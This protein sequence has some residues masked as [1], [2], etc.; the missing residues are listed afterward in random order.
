MSDFQDDDIEVNGTNFS[1][2]LKKFEGWDS[3]TLAGEGYFLAITFDDIPE[4][5][6]AVKVGLVP[7]ASGMAMQELDED[8]DAVFKIADKKRQQLRVDVIGDGKVTTTMYSL[9]GLTLE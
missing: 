3:G 6:T 2:T 7:S 4:S 9:S 1:G 8:K 5:A